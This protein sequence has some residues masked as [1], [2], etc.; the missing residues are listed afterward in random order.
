MVLEEV[1]ELIGIQVG[2]GMVAQDMGKEAAEA[3][4]WVGLA[5]YVS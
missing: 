1:L 2:V 4:D 5:S 3:V